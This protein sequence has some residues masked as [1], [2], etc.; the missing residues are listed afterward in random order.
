MNINNLPEKYQKQIEA[1]IK[2]EDAPET[3]EAPPRPVW[4]TEAE[5]QQRCERELIARGY[6]RRT[7]KAIQK[8]SSGKHF[9]HLPKTKGNPI[10]MDLLI[11]NSTTGK[12]IEIE[13]K[14]KDGRLSPEQRCLSLRGEITVC[15]SF[16]EFIEA[17]MKWEK[18]ET[19]K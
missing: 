11:L 4:Q 18:A 3:P 13:L 15:W 7:P 10:I 2:D 1:Q 19:C 8:K 14:I 6:E 5:L 9:I 16:D 17:L 12:Y